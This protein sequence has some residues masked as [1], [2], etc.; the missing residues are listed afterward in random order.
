M[1]HRQQPGDAW[2]ACPGS[3]A[4]KFCPRAP[5]L[6]V[7]LLEVGIVLAPNHVRQLVEQRLANA[8]IP[9][10]ACMGRRSSCSGL[11]QGCV[12]ELPD[13]S[14]ANWS[15]ERTGTHRA[16]P[17]H[18]QVDTCMMQQWRNRPCMPAWPLLHYQ[19]HAHPPA[20][21]PHLSDRQCAGAG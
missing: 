13:H 17:M 19:R 1:Q 12:R 6:T 14:V 2:R 20:A 9:P 7:E 5:H 21:P 10:E 11:L 16:Q 15:A 3:A 18:E 4:H 8:V